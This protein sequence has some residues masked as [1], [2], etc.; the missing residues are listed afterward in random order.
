[1]SLNKSK[2]YSTLRLPDNLQALRGD[3]MRRLHQTALLL[4]ATLLA[5]CY[6]NKAPPPVSSVNGPPGLS[7]LIVV[8]EPPVLPEGLNELLLTYRQFLVE[9]AHHLP[10]AASMHYADT[11]IRSLVVGYAGRE[12]DLRRVISR[13]MVP[14]A[15][16]LPGRGDRSDHADLPV[17]PNEEGSR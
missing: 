17:H 12:N 16:Q 6:G 3:I 9:R 13:R 14:P 5:G 2:T 10:P 8:R 1:M 7:P 4:A 15:M 11:E